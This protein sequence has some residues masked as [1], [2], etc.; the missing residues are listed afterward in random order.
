[1][2]PRNRVEYYDVYF[3]MNLGAPSAAS[4]LTRHEAR[5]LAANFAKLPELVRRSKP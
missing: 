2:N 5:R 3:K 4:L 1:L